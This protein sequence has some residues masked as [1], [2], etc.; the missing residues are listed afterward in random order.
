M[1]VLFRFRALVAAGALALPAAALTALV[2]AAPAQAAAACAA[3]QATVTF[4]DGTFACQSSNA[5]DVTYPASPAVV[6]V[7]AGSA[8]EAIVTGTS[9]LGILLASTCASIPGSGLP[10]E[11]TVDVLQAL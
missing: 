4:A 6:Q 11:T 8:A 1:P 9:T 3:S 7:C 2:P 5:G 10:L